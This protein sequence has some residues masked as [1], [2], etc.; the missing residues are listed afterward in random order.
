MPPDL[1]QSFLH[2]EASIF[3]KGEARSLRIP[4]LIPL[5]LGVLGGA[6]VGKIPTFFL[7]CGFLAAIAGAL[8]RSACLDIQRVANGR[9]P[10][11][12]LYAWH[13][14]ALA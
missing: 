1:P 14:A 5:G 2:G 10:F 11:A 6:G 3:P 7:A 8:T 12:P 13:F 4:G 9:K